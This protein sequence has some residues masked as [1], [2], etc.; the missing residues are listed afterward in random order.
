M[1]AIDKIA[2]YNPQIE[3]MIAQQRNQNQPTSPPKEDDA[4][5][6]IAGATTGAMFGAAS[7][8]AG[9][10]SGTVGAASGLSFGAL[11]ARVEKPQQENFKQA[12]GTSNIFQAQPNVDGTGYANPLQN[13]NNGLAPGNVLPEY[14]TK[15]F[16]A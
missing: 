10:V 7:M 16:I 12:V 15:M 1:G 9:A 8:G 2:Q 13:Y 11:T 14:A 5:A 6:A 3:Q 4:N